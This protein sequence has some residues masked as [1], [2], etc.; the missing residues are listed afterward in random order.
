M[1][2]LITPLIAKH[3]IFPN[4][5]LKLIGTKGFYQWKSEINRKIK[6]RILSE[7]QLEKREFVLPRREFFARVE[8]YFTETGVSF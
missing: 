1:S 6:E 4:I 3:V 5:R 8:S 7:V 2:I